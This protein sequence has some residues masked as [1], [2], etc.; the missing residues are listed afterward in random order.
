MCEDAVVNFVIS[1]LQ[2]YE[3][4]AESPAQKTKDTHNDFDQTSHDYEE[5]SAMNNYEEPNN[6][7]N[8]GLELYMQPDYVKVDSE[9]SVDNIST[10]DYDDIGDEDV[11]KEEEEE[12]DYDDIGDDDVEEEDY[13]DVC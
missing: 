6:T 9:M 12:E 8:Q 5:F 10:E 13:D 2:N 1:E 3:N 11:A 4:L 7:D